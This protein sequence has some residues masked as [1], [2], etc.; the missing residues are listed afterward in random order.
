MRILSTLGNAAVVLSLAAGLA[1]LGTVTA[2]GA[3]TV[4]RIVGQPDDGKLVRLVGNTH[5]M[6]RPRYDR[7]RLDGGTSMERLVLLLKRS[8][9]QE[10]ALAAFN[11]R[12]YQEG[13]ADYHHWLHAEEFGKL[14]GPSDAD[15]AKVK[16]WLEREGFIVDG[17]SKGRVTLEFS[18]TAANVEDAFHV[19]MH[20]YLVNGEK[21][22]A[23]DRDPSIP[24]A[25]APVVGGIASL[26]N[27]FPKPQHVLGKFVKR[28]LKTGE[29]TDVNP[30]PNA[31]KL[32][33]SGDQV[34]TL[35]H[36][37]G[38]VGEY[39]YVPTGGDYPKEDVTPYDFA[40]IYNLLPLWNAG[41]KGAGQTVAI[42]GISD[43]VAKD[44]A[45]FRSSFGLP[46]TPV[47]E[48]VHNGSDP[49]VISGDSTENTLDVEMS[50]A[51]A[52][53][54]QI[55]LVV[56]ASTKTTSGVQLSLSYIVDNETAPIMSASY[57]GCELAQGTTG[58]ATFNSIYQQGATEG[59]SIFESSGDQ[60]SAGCSDSD[61]PG[62]NA[63][64][65]GLQVNGLASSPYVTAVGGTDFTWS[66]ITGGPAKYWNTTNA[67][68]GS[69]AKGYIP[70]TPWNSTCAN[71]L[72]FT[73]FT[74][75]FT[76]AEQFCNAAIGS[77]D[78]GLIVITG[79]SGGKSACTTSS[80]GF[81]DS[82]SGGY[83][84]PTWQAGKGVPADGKRDL[85]D[86]S[87]FASAGFPDGLIGS[88]ILF[89]QSSSSPTSSCDYSD[90]DYIIYQEIGG[91]S[92]SSPYMA[93]VMAL[94]EEK[95]GGKQ[96]LANPTFYSLATKQVNAGTQCN[97]ASVAS[98][99][100]C[101][102]YDSTAGTNAQVCY[103]GDQNCTTKISGD[104]L[105]ILSG[106]ATTAGY[107][108]GI[109]LGSMNVT[110][111]V[112]AWPTTAETTTSALTVSATTL[113]VGAK[114]T[115]TATVTAKS[116]TPTGTVSFLLNGTSVGSATLSG[117]KATLTVSTA[118]LA[119]GTYPATASYAGVTG[120]NPSTSP[121]VDVKLT[122]AT[123]TTTLTASATSV[124]VGAKVTLTATVTST[125]NTV[126]GKV[127]FYY[128]TDLL[129]SAT[130]SGGKAAFT[131]T[132]NVP[133][134][135][136][137]VNA[138]YEGSTEIKTSTS[139]KVTVTVK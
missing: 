59:I 89:C 85:P 69:N 136:Y 102:F 66:F 48:T 57:G 129:G 18:G 21:H 92:A 20:N 91:T 98:G 12:Q 8:P 76:S 14:Y 43:I 83:A 79:G 56:S 104:E 10:A 49:G 105:G 109:G 116:G 35:K 47:F 67:S 9:E 44:V 68:N 11:E 31:S 72:V 64:Q 41:T 70:E 135:S 90:P 108:Q 112:N 95:A 78:E 115:L 125:G 114:L 130:V 86:V 77:N 97:S 52:P 45:T 106:Y 34:A 1:S 37:T 25:L 137:A 118:G 39:G 23:N 134:G 124:N 28:N 132:A 111:L 88:A 126:T 100:T 119:P 53:S 33:E 5:P 4:S 13:S 16:G 15:I 110:N 38:P 75:G 42:S 30:D 128:T 51:A 58:N 17:V 122:Q 3:Q 103:T 22:V 74:N 93:G 40:A 127:N 54:A 55:I 61:T 71:P 26:N 32:S 139:G 60:G 29:I 27:F 2:A 81:L 96:G 94:V 131:A 50:G 36:G 24:A 87:F 46:A 80:G 73:I 138:V 107:D 65:Y 63:D 117:G 6:A 82:C 113:A 121:A 84:K 101:V 123:S 120:F 99:N 62:P 19:E 133:E 7:G